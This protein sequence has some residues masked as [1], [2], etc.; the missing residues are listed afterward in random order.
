[1]RLTSAAFRSNESIPRRYTG[2]GE[3]ISPPLEW[4]DV[5]EGTRSLVLICEDPDAPRREGKDHPFTHWVLYNLSPE[6]SMLPEGVRPKPRLEL[7]VLTDQGVSSF[8][9]VGY[10]GPM[11][12]LESGEHHYF[13]TLYA[14]N[15][16]YV[17]PPGVTKSVVLKAMQGAVLESAQLVGRYRRSHARHSLPHFGL[18]VDYDTL[19]SPRPAESQRSLQ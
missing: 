3:N 13:F 8:G 1:M 19:N 17:A 10:G 16:D 9:E 5:P 14:L 7:P 18:R 6:T 2:E 12:P 4:S 11:P 15:K